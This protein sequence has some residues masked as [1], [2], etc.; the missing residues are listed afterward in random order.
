MTKTWAWSPDGALLGTYPTRSEAVQVTIGREPTMYEK[1]KQKRV[2]GYWFTSTP[3]CPTQP[4]RKLS[5][6]PPKTDGGVQES[7]RQRILND[8]NSL[9]AHIADLDQEKRESEDLLA[10][11]ETALKVLDTYTK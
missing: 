1:T 11:L 10:E 6:A 4:K 3:D 5:P 2:D 7:P 9:K 8:I